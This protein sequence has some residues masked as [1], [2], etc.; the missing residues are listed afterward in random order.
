[1]TY[2]QYKLG[3]DPRLEPD[4]SSDAWYYED[5]KNSSYED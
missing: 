3:H 5:M 2:D 1:M 4:E